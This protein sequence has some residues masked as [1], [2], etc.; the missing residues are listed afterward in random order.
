MIY[1]RVN[2]S[3]SIPSFNGQATGRGQ[4][5]Y[6]PSLA[7]LTLFWNNP[8]AANMEIWKR[9]GGKR[10]SNPPKGDLICQIA[11]DDLRVLVS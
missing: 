3:G 9:R 2:L 4:D 6:E 1:C 10:P 5:R 8:K 7:C 11:V